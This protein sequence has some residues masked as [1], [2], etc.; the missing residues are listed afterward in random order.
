VGSTIVAELSRTNVQTADR[1]NVVGN[2]IAYNGTLVLK[3]IG[4]PLQVGDTFTVFNASSYS[5]SFTLVSQTLGQVVTWNTANLAVNGTVSVAAVAQISL[6][7]VVTGNTLNLTWPPNQLG[8]TLQTNSVSV[9]APASWFALPG[10]AGVTN[11]NITIDPNL[12]NVFFRLV[13]P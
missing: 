1:I 3:N 8:M 12:P 10:S 4:T 5:G 6:V 7:P 9:A 2:P 13:A 11:V